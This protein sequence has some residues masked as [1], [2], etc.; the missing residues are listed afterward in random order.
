MIQFESKIYNFIRSINIH[1]FWL[2]NITG[3]ALFVFID[4]LLMIPQVEVTFYEYLIN[5]I[6]WFSAF[7]LTP[8]LRYVYKRYL[9][10]TKP[11]PVTIV[12]IFLLSLVTSI[13]AYI[14]AH[15]I[16]YLFHDVD[17]NKFIK[18]ITSAEF[19]INK[20]AQLVPLFVTW[21]VLYFGIKLWFDLTEEQ[22]RAEKADLMARSSQLEMLRYQLNPHFLFNTLSS[23]R[24]LVTVNPEKAETMITKIS[25]FLRYSLIDS[26]NEEVPL[27]REI[28]I[29]RLYFDI[30]NVR[31]GSDLVAEFYIDREAEEYPIPIFMIH[32]LVENAVK[33]GMRTSPGTLNITV[34]AKVK[35]NSLFVS[36]S[37]TG[38]WVEQPAKTESTGKG[39]ENIK[40]RL[41]I[42][43][44]GRH[45]FEIIKQEGT[46]S[47]ELSL[48]KEIAEYKNGS[49]IQSHNY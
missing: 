34:T 44:P 31:F 5:T 17:F 11:I 30:E 3:W 49:K 16:Y 4:G 12:Y 9:Y 22:E 38:S 33:Y 39:I 25:E 40:R 15:I 36:V 45:T 47:V 28:E 2:V 20:H 19:I 43:C 14:N 13:I 18:I 7:L 10:R 37:N 41:A 6:A 8:G 1:S 29:I 23:L 35:N 27:R 21:S 26:E 24:A 46:V 32:P 48:T 42:C